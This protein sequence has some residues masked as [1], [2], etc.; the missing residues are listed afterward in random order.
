MDKL[1][2][3]FDDTQAK[4][5]EYKKT[6]G[7]RRDSMRQ[8][9]QSVSIEHDGLK[10]SWNANDVAREIDDVEKRLKHY[11]RAI[12]ELKEFVETKTRETDYENV[13]TQCLRLGDQLNAAAVKNSNLTGTSGGAGDK[14]YY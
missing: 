14:G 7:K 10:K 9:V 2:R 13:R 8:Q 1:R 11:E 3:E 6:Y 4:L 12:F 5:T